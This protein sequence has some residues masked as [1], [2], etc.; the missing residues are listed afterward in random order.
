MVRRPHA[1]RLR[2]IWDFLSEAA[3]SARA[4]G[5]RRSA[6][7]GRRACATRRHRSWKDLRGSRQPRR[8]EHEGASPVGGNDET[9]FP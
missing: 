5:R 9:A 8:L 6:A 4:P 1:N 2:V 7:V 3:G